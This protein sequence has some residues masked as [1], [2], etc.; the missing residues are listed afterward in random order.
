MLNKSAHQNPLTLN[1]GTISE[2]K[3]INNAFITKVNNQIVRIFIGRVRSN[4][5][6]FMKVFTIHKTIATKSAVINPETTTQGK[7]YAVIITASALMSK[8]IM[9]DIEYIY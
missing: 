8:F 9:I 2:T 4:I 3:R 7:R 5:R 6:G 1:Q